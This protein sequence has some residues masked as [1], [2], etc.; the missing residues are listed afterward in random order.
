MSWLTGVRSALL[1]SSRP[2]LRAAGS[3]Q[4]VFR[5]NSFASSLN[6]LPVTPADVDEAALRIHG[7]VV[8]TPLVFSPVLSSLLGSGI[9]L[10]CENLQHIHAFKAR[11]ACNAVFSLTEEQA[12]R[13]VVCHSS[14]NHAAAVAMAAGLRGIPAYVVMPQNSAPVKIDA[15]RRLGVDP[16]FCGPSSEERAGAAADLQGRT[17][18]CLIHP[19]ED[20]RVIAGQGTVGL[21]IL[22]QFAEQSPDKTCPDRI[23]CPIGGGGIISGVAVA[24]KHAAPSIEVVGAEPAWADDAFR[25]LKNDRLES[26]VRYDSIGDGLRSGLGENTFAV[27]RTLVDGILTASE[28]AIVGAVRMF[29]RDCKLC[30]EPS[31]AVAWAALTE[32]AEAGQQRDAESDTVLILTGGN[33]ALPLEQM[34]PGLASR[35]FSG[36]SSGAVTNAG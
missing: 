16:V 3:V 11:G 22:K 35:E 4:T 14:G 27:I 36:R 6:N 32:A 8:Q 12:S 7:K 15:V 24:V 31:G 18:A 30:V 25:S 21:E 23:I 9:W 13:G 20:P 2:D 26:P 29:A 10:K 33:F 17:G 19:S 5:M 1:V 28:E 34:L